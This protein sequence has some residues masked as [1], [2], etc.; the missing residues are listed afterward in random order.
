MQQVSITPKKELTLAELEICWIALKADETEAKNQR[1]EIEQ[2][3]VERFGDQLKD[4]G[5]TNL[6]HLKVSQGVSKTYDQEKLA[7][8]ADAI[9]ENL[10]PFNPTYKEDPNGVK[11]IQQTFPDVWRL[12]LDAVIEKPKKPSF[13]VL[14]KKEEQAA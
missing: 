8:I 12:I 3:I 14:P 6:S 9:P 11:Y 5:T 10:F 2:A 4:R 13:S 7:E 1:L